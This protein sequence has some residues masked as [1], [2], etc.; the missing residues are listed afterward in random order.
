MFVPRKKEKERKTKQKKV[1]KWINKRE[2][3]FYALFVP[4]EQKEI[5]ANFKLSNSNNDQQKI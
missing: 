5:K 2:K 4:N 1:D 3:T